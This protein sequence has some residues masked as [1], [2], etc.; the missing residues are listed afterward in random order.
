MKNTFD[1]RKFLAEN[2]VTKVEDVTVEVE[3]KLQEELD[4]NTDNTLDEGLKDILF[5]A[6]DKMFGIDK[7]NHC[8]EAGWDSSEECRKIKDDMAYSKVKSGFERGAGSAVTETEE[9]TKEQAFKKSI[10]DILNS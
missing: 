8:M 7:F 10:E 1:L 2:K 4:L 6:I 5:K 3:Q 9:L